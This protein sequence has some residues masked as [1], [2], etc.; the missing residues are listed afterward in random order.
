MERIFRQDVYRAGDGLHTTYLERRRQFSPW[1][2]RPF[3]SFGQYHRN[4]LAMEKRTFDPH[5]TRFIIA[6]SEM[7]RREIIATYQFPADRIVRVHNGTNVH[8]FQKGD[9]AATRARFGIKDNEYLLLFVGSG[10]RRKGLDFLLSAFKQMRDPSMKLLVVGRDRPP[11]IRPANVIFS[12]PM[13]DIE[14]AYAA[15]D[16]FVLTPFYD[17]FS[18]VVIEALAAGLPVITTAFNG[19]SEIPVPG[20]TGTIIDSPANIPAIMDAIRYWRSRPGRIHQPDSC[21]LSMERNVQQTIRVLEDAVRA[22]SRPG[23]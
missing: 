18:N 19:A 13:P 15:A 21:D 10:W 3:N 7:V 8:R 1:W 14:N 9:R 12:R 4:M 17:P 11:L 20:V 6:N 2:R 22:Q 16:L 5:N 23:A